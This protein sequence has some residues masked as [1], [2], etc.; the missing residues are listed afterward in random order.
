MFNGKSYK[1][2]FLAVESFTKTYSNF[3]AKLIHS[4][5][6]RICGNVLRELSFI[7]GERDCVNVRKFL[8]F[9]PTNEKIYYFHSLASYKHT[10][11]AVSIRVSK[12]KLKKKCKLDK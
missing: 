8:I 5:L 12:A 6:S 4:V 9:F 10:F 11:S 2:V 1:G 3:G 7:F